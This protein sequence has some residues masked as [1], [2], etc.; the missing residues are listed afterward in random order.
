MQ[1]TAAQVIPNLVLLVLH[2]QA[3]DVVEVK[4][5]YFIE[6]EVVNHKR[7]FGQHHKQ[8]ERNTGVE[9]IFEDDL[10]SQQIYKSHS[11]VVINELDDIRRDLILDARLN[12][13]LGVDDLTTIVYTADKVTYPY[14]HYTSDA[15]EPSK[16]VYVLYLGDKQIQATFFPDEST[17]EFKQ[18]ISVTV[19]DLKN[20]RISTQTQ[21]VFGDNT[22]SEAKN[23]GLSPQSSANDILTFLEKSNP[24][25]TLA[26]S[27]E[28]Y[29]NTK[30]MTSMTFSL[31]DANGTMQSVTQLFNVTFK[32]GYYIVLAAE[33]TE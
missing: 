27:F 26:T 16:Y 9:D 5:R 33:Q 21:Y 24:E 15:S 1:C 22:V 11:N 28:Y 13:I 4:R 14:K 25:P 17:G 8:P 32:N 20:G 31:P 19:N 3:A 7:D 18:L 29:E 23:A 6:Q 12:I 2:Q 10:L 30:V